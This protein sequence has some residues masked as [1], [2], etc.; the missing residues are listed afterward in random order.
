MR[1]ATALV[2]L[3]AGFL[4]CSSNERSSGF[5]DPNG[6]GGTGPDDG[7]FGGKGGG[8]GGAAGKVCSPNP[9][10]FDIPGNNCD[11]DGDGTVDNPPSCDD[12]LSANGD[13]E[14]FAR[15]I[16][17][18]TKAADKGY[19]LVSATYTRSFGATQAPP[20]GQ[21]GILPKFGDV[22]KPREG[23]MLGVLSSGY[24]QEFNGGNNQ[25]F[26]GRTPVGQEW[27]MGG[28]LPPGFPKPA[29]GCPID[30]E[31]NDVVTVKLELKAPPNAS[32][33][34]FD[35]NFFSSEWPAYICTNFNDGFLA[36]LSAKGFNGGTADNI[37]FD[38]DKNPVSVNN[39][40]F[41][42][43]TPGVLTGCAGLAPKQSACPGGAAELAGTGFGISGKYCQPLGQDTSVGGGA[44]G[45]LTS[46]APVQAGETFTLE[47]MVWDTGDQILDSSV[48]IDN[49]T[50]QEGVVT[51]STDRP[52]R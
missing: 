32:G 13:A 19:G 3:V 34:A 26:G 25:P 10:N 7:Q 21:H 27:T 15:A 20:A 52:P 42:R 45:W 5:D 40:F 48:L 31:V 46:K 14:A 23:K 8:D 39:G 44:T 47:F 4:A 28:S 29:T 33:V 24:A 22:L 11:D 35:F 9:A 16:G 12:G 38:K 6:N 1:T 2:L 37:S 18:C 41:D 43:C 30:N 50:W 51:T 36:Y 17:V 49:F